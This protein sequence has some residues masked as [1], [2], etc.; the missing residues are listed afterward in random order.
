MKQQSGVLLSILAV[1]TFAGHAATT[2]AASCS[3]SDVQKAV[4]ASAVGDTVVVPSTPCIWSAPVNLTFGITLQGGG[5][6]STVIT[7]SG[8]TALIN[9]QPN[10]TAIANSQPITVTGFTLD[11]GG[12]SLVILQITGAGDSGTIPFRSVIIGNNTFQNNSPTTSGNG[13]ISITG[14]VRGVIYQNTFDKCDVIVK[15]MGNDTTTE[16]ANTAYN[17]VSYGSSDNLF[18]EDNTIMYS[19]SYAGQDPGWVENGQG[20]RIVMR[21]NTWNQAN[22]ATPTEG[23]DI[24]GFQN[25]SGEANSGQT[26]TMIVEYYGNTLSNIGMYRWI[27]H[28][29]TWGLFFNNV[30][31]G[32]SSPDIEIYGMS[33]PGSCPS[34]I[35][36][37]PT[38]Y[39]P[40]VN[41]SYFFNNTVNG[42]NSKA[43]MNS[44]GNPTACS[45]TENS[46]WWNYNSSCTSSAC[47]DR[48]R[49]QRSDRHCSTGE[50]TGWLRQRPLP[51]HPR[52]FKTL[53]FTNALP[54]THGRSTLRHI[55]IHTLCDRA[56]AAVRQSPQ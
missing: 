33:I 7:A 18:F 31:T 3:Q 29:A 24:H 53:P 16:W 47:S 52:S 32:S 51:H 25:W 44:A 34:N 36:P 37:T 14:Q 1:F 4:N 42:T 9:I 22:A 2:N 35:I 12:S 40:V 54:R 46:N 13:A 56:A 45:V 20:G 43:V 48:D 39:S 30:L 50:V 17:G 15:N 27:D 6:G 28:R 8:G 55:P 10:A 49:N 41:N 19:S 23:W 11:G 26:G 38:N 21:Y 5:A